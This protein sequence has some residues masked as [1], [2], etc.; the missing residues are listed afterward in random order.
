MILYSESQVWMSDR[1][2]S[3]VL[4]KVLA[5]LESKEWMG[6][7]EMTVQVLVDQVENLPNKQAKRTI[8]RCQAWKILRRGEEGVGLSHVITQVR[9]EVQQA[10]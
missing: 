3:G 2:R 4:C 5:L 8:T 6:G 7:E 1:E 10:F 9:G